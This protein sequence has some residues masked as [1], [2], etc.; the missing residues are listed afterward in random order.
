M[1][2][3]RCCAAT[4]IHFLPPLLISVSCNE[5]GISHPNSTSGRNE[6]GRCDGAGVR[7]LRCRGPLL[8]DTRHGVAQGHRRGLGATQTHLGGG[9][10][11]SRTAGS[12][13]PLPSCSWGTGGGS[14]GSGGCHLLGIAGSAGCQGCAASGGSQVTA[15]VTVPRVGAVAPR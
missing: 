12:R 5:A 9:G 10:G 15:E 8:A 2:D 14:P 4:G 7:T 3:C 11:T 1:E 6:P 13:S